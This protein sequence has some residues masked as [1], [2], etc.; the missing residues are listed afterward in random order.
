MSFMKNPYEIL[1]LNQNAT[2][3]EVQ[4]AFVQAQ[5]ENVKTRKCDGKELMEARSQLMIPS[6]RLVADFLFPSKIKSKRPKLMDVSALEMEGT[7]Y[8]MN[9]DEFDS[10][11]Y[12]QNYV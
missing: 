7:A 12:C 3:E 10:L 6:K 2:K 4:N 9:D 11:K 8:N 5:I 1:G